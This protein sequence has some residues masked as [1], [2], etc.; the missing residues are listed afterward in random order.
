M[1]FSPIL[2]ESTLDRVRIL[3]GVRGALEN[4]EFVFHY[5]P[6]VDIQNDQVSRVEALIRWDSPERGMVSP[7][8]FIPVV[9]SSGYLWPMTGWGLGTAVEQLYRWANEKHDVSISVN[10][11]AN[12]FRNPQLL[13]TIESSLNL[14]GVDPSC[15]D[16]ELTETAVMLDPNL[17]T[18]ICENLRAMG[19]TISIDDFGVGQS[20]LAYLDRLP[21]NTIKIDREFIVNLGTTEKSDTIVESIIRL[22]TELGLTVVAEGV[23]EEPTI[24]VLREMGCHEIPGYVFAKPAPPEETM[25]WMTRFN[26]SHV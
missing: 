2:E 6:K 16:I 21:I 11:S 24:G 14:W 22:G 20:P 10:V 4:D 13:S 12:T 9:E 19:V 7:G 3:T 17:A 5:Q 23:E 25:S 8:L 18:R 26:L 1:L 15:L